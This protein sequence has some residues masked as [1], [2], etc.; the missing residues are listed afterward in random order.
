[1][2]AAAGRRVLLQPRLEVRVG[3]LHGVAVAVVAEDLQVAQEARLFLE[4]QEEQEV[5]LLRREVRAQNQV[6]VAEGRAFQLF[7][8]QVAKEVTAS[9]A[10]LHFNSCSKLDV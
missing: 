2:A 7:H 4:E 9:F 8:F 10:S 5:H 6:V 1:V 3:L